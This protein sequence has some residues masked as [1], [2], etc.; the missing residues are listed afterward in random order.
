MIRPSS[1]LTEIAFS[2]CTA[3]HSA[4]Y[5]VVMTG[6]SAATFYAPRAYLSDDIDF[7]ITLKGTGGEEAL[8]HLGYH[9]KGD[10]YVHASSRFPIEFPPGPLAIGDDFVDSWKTFRRKR[11]LLHV[12][13]PTDACRDRLA[14]FLF[15]NDFRGLQQAL[16]VCQAQ[17]R[18]VHLDVVRSWCLREHQAEKF[19]LFKQRLDALTLTKAVLPRRNGRRGR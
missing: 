10:Y 6:G 14:S 5:T 3:L 8:E 18:K 2:V 11:Q 7:V 9:R 15:W 13:S 12:L 1:T 16:D 17:R 4:G 19:Q